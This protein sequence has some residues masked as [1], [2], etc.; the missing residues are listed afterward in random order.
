MA[1]AE[2][3]LAVEAL[4]AISVAAASAA[5]VGISVEEGRQ[6]MDR[7]AARTFFAKVRTRG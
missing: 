2:V 4:A 1:V 3:I 7:I 6:A 5:E